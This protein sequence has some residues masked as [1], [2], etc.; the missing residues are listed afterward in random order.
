MDINARLKKSLE[1]QKI[2]AH[3]AA[4]DLEKSLALRLRMENAQKADQDKHN[5]QFDTFE[6]ILRMQLPENISPEFDVTFEHKRNESD[7]I[8]SMSM[9]LEPKPTTMNDMV[10]YVSRLAAG[11]PQGTIY[12]EIC[13][14]EAKVSPLGNTFMGKLVDNGNDIIRYELNELNSSEI[15]LKQLFQD[16]MNKRYPE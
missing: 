10:I 7:K 14:S 5:A 4:E 16:F 15:I 6:R 3:A 2:E 8:I 12:I 9:S 11:D 13:T 1:Q